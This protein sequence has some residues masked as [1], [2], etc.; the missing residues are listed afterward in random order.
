MGAPGAVVSVLETIPCFSLM[1]EGEVFIHVDYSRL[2]IPGK[3]YGISVPTG[4]SS[5]RIYRTNTVLVRGS[6]T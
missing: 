2:V 5:K 6:C 1:G 3:S 4:Q